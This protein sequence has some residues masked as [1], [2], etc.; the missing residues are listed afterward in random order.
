[1]DGI[2]LSNG[3]ISI[4]GSADVE[5]TGGKYGA[6]IGGNG[7][8][9]DNVYCG[10]IGGAAVSG[11]IT[12]YDGTVKAAGGNGDRGD[13]YVGGDGGTAIVGEMT[14]YGGTLTLNAGTGG[15]GK[16]FGGGPN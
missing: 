2:T 8:D 3:K 11:S 6:G 4:S 9:P 7:N 14:V 16:L 12:V 1:M 10:G 13:S 15:K 5:A